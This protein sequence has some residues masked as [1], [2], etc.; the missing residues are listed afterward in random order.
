MGRSKQNIDLSGSH[1]PVLSKLLQNTT[2]S[3]L[4]LGAGFNSTPLLY[5]TCKAQ[6]RFFLSYE[7][8]KDWV[9]K[10]PGMTKYIED[11]DQADIDSNDWDI[12]FIDCRPAVVR[13]QLARH[14]KDKAQFVVLHDSEP[15]I[16]RFYVYHRI[17]PDFK[18]RYNFTAVKP[19]TMILSN[20]SDP[21]LMFRS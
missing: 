8:H 6:Q 2:G 5:W 10:L 13:H 18:Y 15:E 21:N 4:E 14:L 7:N 19:N 17:Y 16:D 9:E 20:F 1:I 11:W 3:V 12:A